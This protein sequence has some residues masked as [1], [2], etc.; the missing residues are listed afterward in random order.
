MVIMWFFKFIT[1]IRLKTKDDPWDIYNRSIFNLFQQ[2][3]QNQNDLIVL[4]RYC[5]KFNLS[6]RNCRDQQRRDESKTKDVE[7]VPTD[8]ALSVITKMQNALAYPNPLP[9]MA[10]NCLIISVTKPLGFAFVI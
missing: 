9:N 2:T 5:L 10:S 1:F 6:G 8:A 4:L 3:V 7:N